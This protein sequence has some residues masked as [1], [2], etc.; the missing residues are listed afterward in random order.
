MLVVTA[1]LGAA[2]LADSD[3]IATATSPSASPNGPGSVIEAHPLSRLAP[4]LQAVAA[5][6]VRVV[7]RSTD[8]ETGR[9]TN[10]SGSLFLPKGVAPQGGWTVVAVGHEGSG[11]DEPCAPSASAT[12]LGEAGHVVNLLRRGHAVALTDYQGLGMPGE[13]HAFLDV[14]TAG[15]N[16]IDS[17]RALRNVFPFVSSRWAAVGTDQGGGGAWSADQQAKSYAPELTMVG[18]VALSPLTDASSLVDSA[19]NGALTERQRTTLLWALATISRQDADFP[20]AE[21]RRGIAAQHWDALTAC[22]GP[23]VHDG[24]VAIKRFDPH[25]LAPSSPEAADALRALMSRRAIPGARLDAPLSVSYQAA[26]DVVEPETTTT[27]IQRACS[28]GATI[29][30]RLDHG[31]V[32]SQREEIRQLDWLADRFAGEPAGNDCAALAAGGA[33][34]GSVLSTEPMS[35][36]AALLPAGSRATRVVYASTRGDTREPSVVSG[37]VFV[38]AG[39]PPEGGWPVLA[40]GHPSTGIDEG[41]APST[42]SFLMGQAQ[43]VT[44]FLQ[45]GYAVALADYEGLGSPGVHPYLDARTAGLN[46]IDAVRALRATYGNVSTRWAAIGESQGAAAVWSADESAATYAPELQLVG[47]VALAP[48][49]DVTGLVDE[50]VDG[51]LN[52]DQLAVFQ[53]I[54]SSL[55]RV[56]PDFD[57]D[58]FR[59]GSAVENWDVLN[60]CSPAHA[61]ERP[62]ALARLRADELA[63]ASPRAADELRTLLQK[64]ALPQRELSAPLSVVFGSD[65]PFIDP[66]WTND[67]IARGCELGDSI[68]AEE[69]AGK[70]HVDLDWAGQIDWLSK[71]FQGD[72]MDGTCPGS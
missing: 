28:T 31:Q 13:V 11:I 32:R 6:S 26:E 72:A 50:A 45:L 67:A 24:T 36:V 56:H 65:D 17:V 51:T 9:S 4:E 21:Y 20:I 41:C 22:S 70:G 14:A 63:P 25:D 57:V 33:S 53:L 8:V 64:W 39:S 59:R 34:A 55:A 44:G 69:Q 40:Y 7:Y 12:L 62:A 52:P 43:A 10:V 47:A 18:A 15:R 19:Q 16:M 35:D 1:V 37:S 58:S 60:S 42:S 5:Q 38:P 49:A 3:V 54:L 68:D 66:R 48:P 23:L 27:A 30:W 29:E 71:R 2:Y 46:V 61:A